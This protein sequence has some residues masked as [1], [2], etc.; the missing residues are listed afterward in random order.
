MNGDSGLCHG[1][2]SV[3][4]ACGGVCAEDDTDADTVED[5]DAAVPCSRMNR[6]KHFRLLLHT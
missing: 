2:V 5:A 4:D 6:Y 3:D 1:C